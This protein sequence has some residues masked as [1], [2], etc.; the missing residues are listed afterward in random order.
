MIFRNFIKVYNLAFDTNQKKKLYKLLIIMFFGTILELCG[1]GLIF[2]L[3]KIFTDQ[4]F[5]YSIYGKFGIKELKFELLLIYS[6]TLFVLFFIFKNLYLW[7][8]LKRYSFF[9]AN[10]QAELQTKLF[11]GYINKSVS[12]FKNQNSSKIINDIVNISSIFC[13]TYINSVVILIMDIIIQFNILVLLLFVS[14]KSTSLIFFIFGGISYLLYAYSRKKLFLIGQL[15]NKYSAL[16]L[17][18]VQ[19]AIGG[20]KEI[21]LTGRENFFNEEFSKKTFILS[22][23]SFKNALI[24]GAPRLFVEFIAVS[25]IALLVIFLNSTGSGI[26]DIIPILALFLAAAYKLIPSLNKILLLFNRIKLSGDSVEK[27][28]FLIKEFNEKGYFEF[29]KED[30]SFRINDFENL[31]VKNLYFKYSSR[32]EII[33]NNININFKKNSF[34]GIRGESGSGKSTLLDLIMGIIDPTE[35]RIDLDNK[36]ISESLRKWQ[37]SIGYV[38][39]NIFLTSGT[40]KRNIAFGVDEEKID[41]K[42][43]EDVIYKSSLNKFVEELNH[44]FDTEIGEGG[45][46]IS[47]GQ[48]QRIGIARA[49][50]NKPKI[51]ILD[52]ATSA[53]DLKTENEILGELNKLKNQLTMISISHKANTLKYCDNVYLL[54]NGNLTKIDNFKN[55]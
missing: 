12:F 37:R 15:R 30:E 18:V 9:F 54:S 25:S 26:N 6:I 29:N 7:F 13:S 44:G 42:L 2:P 33:L 40:L 24:S 4:E 11:R 8:V 3:I 19:Q 36:S 49:L 1:I 43:L 17:G 46:L 31:N 45:G 53:L 34:T 48:R 38:S 52:E 27:I 21:K 5:L 35:G 23:Q 28:I 22:N 16:Q 51:L 39:Q 14:W 32:N 47:G 50:Y 41:Y 10:Y 55:E 20:I